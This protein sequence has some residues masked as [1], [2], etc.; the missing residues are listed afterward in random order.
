MRGTVL[1]YDNGQGVING[2]DGSR[3]TFTAADWK[4]ATSAA[5]PTSVGRS[6]TDA[7]SSSAMS[8]NGCADARAGSKL[9]L[10]DLGAVTVNRRGRVSSIAVNA[11]IPACAPDSFAGYCHLVHPASADCMFNR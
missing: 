3:Y 5:P 2:D 1:G 4:G 7:A 10:L 9:V 11:A 6:P 8:S